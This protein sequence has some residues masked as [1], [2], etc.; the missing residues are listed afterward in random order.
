MSA[1]FPKDFLLGA[2]TSAYQIEGAWNEDGKGESIWDRFAHTPGTIE[3]GTTGD[4]ACDHVHRFAEDVEWMARLGL[5]AYRFSLSWPRLLPRGT[6]RPNPAGIAFYDRLIDALLEKKIVPFPTLYHW[7]LP[8]ALQD[9]GGWPERAIVD[10]FGEYADL[11]GRAFGDRA[12]DWITLN[13]PFVSAFL[14]YGQGVHAPG[15]RSER[16]ALAAVHH[17]LLAHGAS[18]SILRERV[19]GGR[20]GISLNLSPAHAASP[21]DADRQAAASFDAFLNRTFLDPLSG[22]GYPEG[23]PYDRETLLSFVRDGDLERITSPLDFLGVNYYARRVVRDET[24]PEEKNAPRTVRPR[25]EKTQ[26]DWEV[27]P[28]GLFEILDRL[29]RDYRFPGYYVT[30]NGA[31]YPDRVEPDGWVRDPARAS[32]LARHIGEARRAVESGVPLR[33]YFVWSL[34]DN[35]EWTHGLG[36]RFGL[37]YVNFATGRRVPKTSF[38]WYRDLISKRAIPQE[39]A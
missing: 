38:D 29:R 12:K 35:F 1:S 34:L 8:Q 36:R 7:D 2:S 4:V 9:R 5:Q 33:G 13:E 11:V 39:P 19:R 15:H 32:Y 22:R 37:V 24:I 21:S 14:G 6:G 26:M 18:V 3:D 23:V 31:A 25:E 27:Y 17:L 16:E 10:A 20:I 30:E 28:E